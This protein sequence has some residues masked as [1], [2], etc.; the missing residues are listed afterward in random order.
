MSFTHS[1]SSC[2]P[3]STSQS[4]FYP[5]SVSLCICV[6]LFFFVLLSFSITVTHSISFFHFSVYE[7]VCF[8]VYVYM[9]L[10][11]SLFLCVF[12]CEYVSLCHICV[13][14]CVSFCGR[15]SLT[16]HAHS[17]THTY[18]QARLLD[19]EKTK[20]SIVEHC[21]YS[22]R[23]AVKWNPLNKSG[24][25]FHPHSTCSNLKTKMV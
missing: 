23:S 12:V 11:V 1:I 20:Q 6:S 8:P 7:C 21:T 25:T 18:T 9:S 15:L 2:V 3:L 16:T 19:I 13:F 5:L 24:S 17:L 14:V 10:S 4:Q 22:E